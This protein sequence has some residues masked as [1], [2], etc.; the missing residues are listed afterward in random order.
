M[1]RA[2]LL[3]VIAAATCGGSP[4]QP[5]PSGEPK[6]PE[7]AAVDDKNESAEPTIAP[8]TH[9]FGLSDAQLMADDVVEATTQARRTMIRDGVRGVRIDAP[10]VVDGAESAL[11]AV[12]FRA[13]EGV[14]SASFAPNGWWI[15]VQLDQPGFVAGS[16]VS[17]KM[18]GG[19]KAPAGGKMAGGGKMPAGGK[20]ASGG[21]MAGGGAPTPSKGVVSE[22]FRSNLRDVLPGLSWGDGVVRVYAVHG[23]DVSNGVT[24]TATGGS[25]SAPPTPSSIAHARGASPNAGAP[26]EL[27]GPASA[28][29]EPGGTVTL[30]GSIQGEGASATVYMFATKGTAAGPFSAQIEVPLDAGSGTFSVN[31]LGDNPLPKGPGIWHVYAFSGEHVAGPVSIELTAGDKPW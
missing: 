8:Q 28:V 30:E 26:I 12:G 16:T 4:K 29:T 21:K 2:G 9:A 24:V 6:T 31:L 18:A 13:A 1:T 15:G 17:A 3:C 14:A 10:F 25:K 7:T 23:G 11:P 27:S 20:T 19:G 5:E 22:P